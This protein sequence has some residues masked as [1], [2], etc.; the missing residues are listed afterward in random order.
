M[1]YLTK[2][3]L[4]DSLSGGGH[5]EASVQKAIID[6]LIADGVYTS[7]PSNLRAEVDSFLTGAED[8]RP[9]QVLDA[10]GA[11]TIVNTDHDPSL[12]VIIADTT[13]PASVTVKGATDVFVTVGTGNDTITLTGTGHDTALGGGGNDHIYGNGMSSLYAGTGL[14]TVVG[15]GGDNVFGNA[16]AIGE[17]ILVGGTHSEVHSNSVSFGNALVSGSDTTPGSADTLYGGGGNDSLYGGHG[18]DQLFAGS[19]DTE[20]VAGT[21]DHQ[22]LHGGSGNDTLFGSGLSTSMDTLIGGGGNDTLVGSGFDTMLGGAGDDVFY[23]GD[24]AESMKGGAGNDVFNITSHTGN[25]TIIGGSG[26]DQVNFAGR[27]TADIDD[28]STNKNGVTHLTFTDGQS[29]VIKGVETLNFTD[30]SKTP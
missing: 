9:V 4:Q 27:S 10:F 23:A 15:S 8:G 19:G 21:G 29:F 24:A 16:H 18:N 7:T 25:D 3:E 26:N 5:L 11:T 12:K 2:H 6:Q 20:L 28:M 17:Q 13:A 30:G 22:Y 14:D 1:A